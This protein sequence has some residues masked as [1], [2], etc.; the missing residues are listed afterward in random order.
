MCYNCHA[1]LK[2]IGYLKRFNDIYYLW[3][4]D[5]KLRKIIEEYK[6]KNKL[7]IGELLHSLIGTELDKVIKD[8][9]IEMIIPIPVSRKRLIER[10][11]NQVEE[12][13]KF[14]GY[15]YIKA[16]RTKDTKHMYKILNKEEREKNI[17]SA[18]EI[19]GLEN[20]NRVLIIDDII[21]TGSTMKEFILEI[22]KH[23][24]K[25]DIVVFTLALSKT[26]R[27]INLN[28]RERDEDNIR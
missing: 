2:K 5:K 14:G 8:E 12:L 24:K 3:D 27:K 11:F 4:Y 1:N 6:F 20:L 23:N 9:K 18:F 26:A 25:I 13:L 28:M 15:P 22:K 19:E 17:K 16:T 21:T 10:G 7:Y